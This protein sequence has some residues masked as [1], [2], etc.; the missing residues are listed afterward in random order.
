[1]FNKNRITI[2]N[3]SIMFVGVWNIKFS[4]LDLKPMLSVRKDPRIK[5]DLSSVLAFT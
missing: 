5:Y 2:I 1:M 4:R 3:L